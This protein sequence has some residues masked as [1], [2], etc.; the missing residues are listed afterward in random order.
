MELPSEPLVFNKA[1]S[2]LSGPNDNIV[3]W[4]GSKAL[5]WE[6]ELG[7]VIGTPAFQIDE[8]HALDHVAGYCIVHDVSERNWQVNRGGQWGKGKSAPGYG[9]IGPWLVTPDEIADPQ[10]LEIELRVNGVIMQSASTSEM[11]FG[12]ATLISHLS[13]FMR[14]ER[15]DVISTGTPSGIG[16]ARNP[17]TYLK[18]GD[19]VD[20]SITGLGK[21]R[22]RVVL[23]C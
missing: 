14:L 2:C 12:V 17:P 18:V 20:L 5:D 19:V 15:G 11:I 22:Q 10:D 9:P 13:Q 3:M 8:K 21:Q 6:V 7:V 16:A 4:P 1:T 23:P